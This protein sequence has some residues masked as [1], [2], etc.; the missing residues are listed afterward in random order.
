[1]KLSFGLDFYDAIVFGDLDGLE[2]SEFLN[3]K[4]YV[5]D[6]DIAHLLASSRRRLSSASKAAFS[7]SKD[8][9]PDIPVV[10]SSYLGEINR[11]FSL[12]E[13]LAKEG[14]VSPLS[15]SLSVHNAISATL[16]IAN[17]NHSQICAISA[18]SVME[19]ALLNAFLQLNAGAKSVLC[20]GLYDAINKPYY[21]VNTPSAM[22]ALVV[23]KGD[24][25]SLSYE[26]KS[27]ASLSPYPLLNFVDKFK[28][29]KSFEC[30]DEK[31]RWRYEC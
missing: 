31:L 16:A 28:F 29:S 4:H 11:Y 19:N 2:N 26:P 30:Y 21:S 20:L 12:Q 7:L 14:L 1:M 27:G 6:F 22:A 15:F 18:F 9:G 23:R 24:D 5:K 13:E 8:I 17:K 25:F 10:F 3:L